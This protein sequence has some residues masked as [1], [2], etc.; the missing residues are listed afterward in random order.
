MCMING[1]ARVKYF[2]IEINTLCYYLSIY[3][4]FN[5]IETIFNGHSFN[6]ITYLKRNVAP[7]RYCLVSIVVRLKSPSHFGDR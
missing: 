5:K 3:Y 1:K 2:C 4:I 7:E 6:T